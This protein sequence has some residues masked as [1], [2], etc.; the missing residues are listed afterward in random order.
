MSHG[1]LNTTVQIVVTPAG[2]FAVTGDVREPGQGTLAGVR[3]LEPVSGS[4]ALTDQAGDYMLAA[5]ASTRLLFEK[6]GLSRAR[7]KSR[8]IDG[9]YED[10]AN[11]PHYGRRDGSRSQARAH[12]HVL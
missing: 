1:S 11:C 7:W 8:R 10:A 5:L 3:V 9:V 2:T 6:A 4:A 12:G